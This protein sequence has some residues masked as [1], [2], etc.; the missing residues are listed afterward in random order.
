MSSQGMPFIMA[1]FQ[2]ERTP[3]LAMITDRVPTNFDAVI[4][5]ET[6]GRATRFPLQLTGLITPGSELDDFRAVEIRMRMLEKRLGGL[7]TAVPVVRGSET[8]D[9][10]RG[11][12]KFMHSSGRE[13]D[14]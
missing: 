5:H 3:N 14:Y 13:I 11:E 12:F 10:F 8:Y 1:E 2:A 4:D 6:S 7:M 9:E